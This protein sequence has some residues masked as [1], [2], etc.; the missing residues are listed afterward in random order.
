MVSAKPFVK[1][2]SF[3]KSEK[4]GLVEYSYR[5]QPSPVRLHLDKIRAIV[6]DQNRNEIRHFTASIRD[7][8]S[9]SQPYHAD[10]KFSLK[11]VSAQIGVPG[12]EGRTLTWVSMDSLP[13]PSA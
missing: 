4:T 6:N 1:T 12:E 11:P 2:S 10:E 7:G 9:E 3:S 8:T 5:A 13:G